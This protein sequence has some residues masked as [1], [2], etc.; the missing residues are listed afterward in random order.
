MC[1]DTSDQR[2]ALKDVTTMTELATFGA[3]CFWGV[4]AAYRQIEGVVSTAVGYEGGR[5]ENP[6]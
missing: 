2:N 5:T 1:D 3:G 6:T 4:E